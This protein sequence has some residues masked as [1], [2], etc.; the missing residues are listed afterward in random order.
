MIKGDLVN[1]TS[2]LIPH[3]KHDVYAC[4]MKL[5]CFKEGNL[6]FEINKVPLG[7]R[8]LMKMKLYLSS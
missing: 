6:F 7:H 5:I 8:P 1:K 2:Y 3:P 4:N